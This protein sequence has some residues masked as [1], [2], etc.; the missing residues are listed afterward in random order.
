ML[1]EIDKYQPN[2]LRRGRVEALE[3]DI[4]DG[5]TIFC[6]RLSDPHV[7][8]MNDFISFWQYSQLKYLVYVVGRV[9]RFAVRRKM[10]LS[11]TT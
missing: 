3:K 2:S 4:N 11:T 1:I 9:G 6:N 10:R 8:T 7:V 5:F